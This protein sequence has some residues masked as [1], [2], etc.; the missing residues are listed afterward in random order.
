MCWVDKTRY[1]DDTAEV[2]V[3]CSAIAKDV[4]DVPTTDMEPRPIQ[5]RVW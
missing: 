4:K 1:C 5:S 3:R 2:L